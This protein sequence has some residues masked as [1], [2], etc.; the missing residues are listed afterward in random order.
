V[1]VSGKPV[2]MEYGISRYFLLMEPSSDSVIGTNCEK[3]MELKRD[4]SSAERTIPSLPV[5]FSNECAALV[6]KPVSVM[7]RPRKRST[8]ICDILYLPLSVSR[9]WDIVLIRAA[10]GYSSYRNGANMFMCVISI[11]YKMC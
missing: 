8:S 10:L 4:S 2:V 9:I 7:S 11:V 5:V 3:S 1:R 6:L